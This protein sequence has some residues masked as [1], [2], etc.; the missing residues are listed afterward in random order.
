MCENYVYEG[1]TQVFCGAPATKEFSGLL[2]CDSCCSDLWNEAAWVAYW[3]SRRMEV[4]S[5]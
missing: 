4:C 2:V 1:S 3:E 5:A